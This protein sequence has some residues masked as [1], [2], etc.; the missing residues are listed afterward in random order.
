MV[1]LLN[2]AYLCWT[3]EIPPGVTIVESL[4]FIWWFC[5]RLY[6]R[7]HGDSAAGQQVC[8]VGA[9]TW[10]LAVALAEAFFHE[11]LAS[12]TP[13][14]SSDSVSASSHTGRSRLAPGA[15]F[16]PFLV[17]VVAPARV[18]ATP[19]TAP[20]LYAIDVLLVLLS[21]AVPMWASPLV[22]HQMW[23]A[24]LLAE[25]F[26]HL[27]LW[28]LRSEVLQANARHREQRQQGQSA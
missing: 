5:V 13:F 20:L 18:Q 15:S 26:A 12:F 27:F 24:I 8:S 1:Y 21:C 7:R 14:L 28:K 2:S 16:G 11:A 17:G 19:T 10:L 6:C 4:P 3:G 22:R 25:V 9:C 23:G